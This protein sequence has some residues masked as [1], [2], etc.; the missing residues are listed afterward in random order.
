MVSPTPELINA[1][2]T[3]IE[4]CFADNPDMTLTINRIDPETIM[5]GQKTFAEM[6]ADGQLEQRAV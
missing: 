6:I 3:N 2:L 5:M 1:T 4:D